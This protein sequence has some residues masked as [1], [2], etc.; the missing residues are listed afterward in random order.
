[1][2][3]YLAAGTLWFLAVFAL[4]LGVTFG[5][6]RAASSA[7]RVQVHGTVDASTV[8]SG[9]GFTSVHLSASVAPD[10]TAAGRAT[11]TDVPVAGGRLVVDI[12]CVRVGRD[13]N[14]VD[15]STRLFAILTGPV[16]SAANNSG[17]GRQAIIGVIDGEQ[18]TPTPSPD[19]INADFALDTPPSIT[20]EN[21]GLAVQAPFLR[22]GVR[23]R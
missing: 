14:S 23:I 9:S 3:K 1:M 10:G 19:A 6:A 13:V 5:T 21:A 17:I 15:G 11:F 12:N 8:A 22:G 18:S 16:V 7:H 20:C 4:V 2:K